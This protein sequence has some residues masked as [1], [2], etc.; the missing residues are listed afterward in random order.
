M[1]FKTLVTK[2]VKEGKS[3]TAAKKIA[4]SVANAKMKGAGSGPTAAQK[5]IS[6]GPKKIRKAKSSIKNE[7]AKPKKTSTF[8]RKAGSKASGG[9]Q[10]RNAIKGPKM[11]SDSKEMKPHNMYGSGGVVKFVKT[12]KEHLALKKKGYGHTK[13]K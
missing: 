6:K 12:M 10:D 5:A 3:E 8:M 1:S 2:L 13:K 9:G 7:P 4:G 11:K